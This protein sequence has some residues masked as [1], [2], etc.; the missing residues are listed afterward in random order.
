MS[1]PIKQTSS[2][3][4]SKSPSKIFL[5]KTSPQTKKT[6]LANIPDDVLSSYFYKKSNLMMIMN[7]YSLNKSREWHTSAIEHQNSIKKQDPCIW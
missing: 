6:T 2:I 1:L 5:Q 3:N 4:K 7:M